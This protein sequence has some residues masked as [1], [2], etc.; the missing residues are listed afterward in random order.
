MLNVVAKSFTLILLVSSIFLAGCSDP[1]SYDV[2]KLSEDQKKELEQKL[3]AGEGQKMVGWIVRHSFGG[4]APTAGTTVGQ[5]I[6]EQEEW[7]EKQKEEEAKAAE[8]KKKIDAERK[9]KQEEFG[10][11]LS[12]VLVNK[13]NTVQEYEQKFVTLELAYENKSDKDIQGVKGILRITDI[14]GDKILNI[15][16]SYDEGIKSKQTAVEKHA[17]VKLNQFIDEHMKLWNAE[18]DKLKS[19]FEISTIIFKDGTKMDAPE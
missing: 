2:T 5:A 6:K 17:G 19:T 12:V 16:W 4:I 7:L 8:I 10:R 15:N 9:T 18:Y 13:R 14:F 11:L 3:T 1:K